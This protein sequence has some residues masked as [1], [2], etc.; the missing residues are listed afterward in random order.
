MSSY[1]SSTAYGLRCRLS[2]PAL[3]PCTPAFGVTT[4]WPICIVPF[5][6]PSSQDLSK[7]NGK[8][9]IRLAAEKTIRNGDEIVADYGD[10]YI[11]DDGSSYKTSYVISNK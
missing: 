7:P 3:P 9:Y 10:D 5:R 8:F 6:L 11:F 4:V 2:P 1:Y